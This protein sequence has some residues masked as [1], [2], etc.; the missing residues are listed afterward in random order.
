MDD[1]ANHSD[2]NKESF[3]N[4]MHSESLRDDENKVEGEQCETK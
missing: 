4:F 2:K 3:M 1:L